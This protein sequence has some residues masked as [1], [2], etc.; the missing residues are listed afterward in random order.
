[1]NSKNI[2]S[3]KPKKT[4]YFSNIFAKSILLEIPRKNKYK[5]R[6]DNTLDILTKKFIK[7]A[8]EEKSNIINLEEIRKKM[9]S[10]RRIYDITNVFHGKMILIDIF[11]LF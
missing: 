8:L 10:K 9:K 6:K 4:L 3:E 7:I 2:N 11:I 1:M 5:K